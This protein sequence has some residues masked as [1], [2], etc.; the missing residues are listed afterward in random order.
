MIAEGV[1]RSGQSAW[2]KQE[3]GVTRP[4]QPPL[5][6]STPCLPHTRAKKAKSAKQRERRGA[7]PQLQTAILANDEEGVRAAVERGAD[8]D[9]V[10]ASGYVIEHIA[11]LHHVA[12]GGNEGMVRVLVEDLGANVN[13]VMS[14]GDGLTAHALSPRNAANGD[15]EGSRTARRQYRQAGQGRQHALALRIEH[16]PY[17]G[18]HRS[19]SRSSVPISPSH[20]TS[21]AG[22][23]WRHA[24]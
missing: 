7:Q 2:T 19:S 15:G 16:T 23:E 13:V 1:E 17:A 4:T 18:R 21:S 22:A 10:M 6:H 8:V 11:P 20:P 24:G 5:S 9:A 3:T 12:A 14:Q